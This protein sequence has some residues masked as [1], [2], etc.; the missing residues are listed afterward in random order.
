[1]TVM[2]D[3]IREM[4]TRETTLRRSAESRLS[5]ALETSREGVI[6]VAPMA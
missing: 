6:L 3:N 5:D 2:Q 4:M 1:M